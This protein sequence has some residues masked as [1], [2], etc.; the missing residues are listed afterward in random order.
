LRA[1]YEI[2]S[3]PEAPH[4][5]S[6]RRVRL[7]LQLAVL[8]FWTPC[9]GV[10]LWLLWRNHETEGLSFVFWLLFRQALVFLALWFTV[11]IAHGL[12]RG[13]RT[14]EPKPRVRR[15]AARRASSGLTTVVA[16][17]RYNRGQ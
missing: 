6:D 10:D 4:S 15:R 12:L 8:V 3:P 2:E 17:A 11:S 9:A 14:R 5:G 1:F 7:F 16:P 13:R